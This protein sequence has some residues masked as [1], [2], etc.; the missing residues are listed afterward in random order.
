MLQRIMV[1]TPIPPITVQTVGAFV[2][3]RI[4]RMEFSGA[5]KYIHTSCAS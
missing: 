2:C 3:I 1:I 5:I 4:F